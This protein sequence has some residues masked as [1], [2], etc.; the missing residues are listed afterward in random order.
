VNFLACAHLWEIGTA[1]WRQMSSAII[2][3]Y[4]DQADRVCIVAAQDIAE[5][6]EEIDEDGT[7]M[8][9]ATLVSLSNHLLRTYR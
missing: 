9:A 6:S 8:L 2:N 7:D 3:T 1:V 5:P 4:F